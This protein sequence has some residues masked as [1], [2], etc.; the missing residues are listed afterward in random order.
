MRE[1]QKEVGVRRENG[2]T[3]MAKL[4]K[5]VQEVL[6]LFEA[7]GIVRKMDSSAWHRMGKFNPYT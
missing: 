6:E 3:L 7:N 1:R 5:Y 2:R 4:E